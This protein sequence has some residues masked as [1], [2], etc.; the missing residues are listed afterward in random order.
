MEQLIQQLNN[1]K[2]NGVREALTQQTEQP[3]LYKEL[4]FNGTMNQ[5]I[6]NGICMG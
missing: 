6:Q 5:P 1:L 2:L 4:C 3:N